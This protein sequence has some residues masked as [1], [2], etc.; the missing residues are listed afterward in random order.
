MNVGTPVRLMPRKDKIE[1][2]FYYHYCIG[3]RG[4]IDRILSG[5]H[6]PGFFQKHGYKTCYVVE[7]LKDDVQEQYCL[8]EDL[9]KDYTIFKLKNKI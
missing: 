3:K 7:F 1:Q 9:E 2:E 4:Y 6:L 8:I 5:E